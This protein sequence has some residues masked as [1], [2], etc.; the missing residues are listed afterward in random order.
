MPATKLAAKKAGRISTMPATW[1]EDEDLASLMAEVLANEA[2]HQG[3]PPPT[4]EQSQEFLALMLDRP[5]EVPAQ[6]KTPPTTGRG[7]GRG[8]TRRSRRR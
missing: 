5:E 2:R 7:R 3:K 6:Q 8:R 4:P 1:P